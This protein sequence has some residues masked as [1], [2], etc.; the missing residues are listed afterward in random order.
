MT[1]II[2]AS[3]SRSITRRGFARRRAS[4]PAFCSAPAGRLRSRKASATCGSASGAASSAISA[5]SSATTSRAASCSTTS[6]TCW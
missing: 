4:A 6:S 2:H 3:S 5:R 1:R